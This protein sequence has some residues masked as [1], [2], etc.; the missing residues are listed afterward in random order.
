MEFCLAEAMRAVDR[1]HIRQSSSLVFHC[2]NR[3]SRLTVL[4]SAGRESDLVVR[5]GFLGHVDATAI[6]NRE[7]DA[8]M[9]YAIAIQQIMRE[10]CTA[11]CGA[12]FVAG[13]HPDAFD[14]G[15]FEHMQRIHEVFDADGEQCIQNAGEMLTGVLDGDPAALLFKTKMVTKDVTHAARRT[16]QINS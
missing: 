2:D 15:L 7:L 16:T 6:K 1:E 4:F 12:P 5:R 3:K 13:G 10:F 8:S 14:A 9:S 11:G